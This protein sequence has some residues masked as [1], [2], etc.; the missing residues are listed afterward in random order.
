MQVAWAG[1]AAAALL[2]AQVPA[3]YA[4]GVTSAPSSAV[5]CCL[6]PLMLS[7]LTWPP[8]RCRLVINILSVLNGNR[9]HCECYGNHPCVN[10]LDVATIRICVCR[11][12]LA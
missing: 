9:E 2:T 7:S 5:S 10:D 3:S 12:R 1:V 8:L 4:A 11:P 6:R